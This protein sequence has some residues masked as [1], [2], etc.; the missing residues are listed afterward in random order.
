MYLISDNAP[1]PNL[2]VAHHVLDERPCTE[3]A[4]PVLLTAV[5]VGEEIASQR[6]KS[7][8]LGLRTALNCLEILA[9]RRELHLSSVKRQLRDTF[10][11]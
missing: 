2:H 8:F 10:N 6:R 9:N 3:H 7:Q 4:A 1:E 11:L 5:S